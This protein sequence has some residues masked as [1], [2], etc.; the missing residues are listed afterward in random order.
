VTLP[1]QTRVARGTIPETRY[2]ALRARDDAKRFADEYG[3]GGHDKRR[4][5]ELLEMLHDLLVVELGKPD[6]IEQQTFYCVECSREIRTVGDDHPDVD[7]ASEED[8]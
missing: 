7:G 6:V 3:G 1:I 4:V 8:G 2:E 5:A